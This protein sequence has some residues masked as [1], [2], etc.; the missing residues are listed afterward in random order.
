MTVR[1]NI[2]S[3]NA[4]ASRDFLKKLFADFLIFLTDFSLL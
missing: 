1:K 4:F 3:K 2:I